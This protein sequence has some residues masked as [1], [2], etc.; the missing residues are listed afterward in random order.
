ME[1]K[2][3]V[4]MEL[5]K[6]LQRRK[7]R[8]ILLGQV[9]KLGLVVVQLYKG[10]H[11]PVHH[12][13]HVVSRQHYSASLPIRRIGS[14]RIRKERERER[15]TLIAIP[16]Q[17][18]TP[19]QQIHPLRR[20]SLLSLPITK[21]QI[22]LPLTPSPGAHDQK[23]AKHIQCLAILLRDTP[24]LLLEALQGDIVVL[25]CI[26]MQLVFAC[27]VEV[28]EVQGGESQDPAEEE[29]VSEGELGDDV[30]VDLCPGGQ[31]GEGVDCGCGVQVEELE[32]LGVEGGV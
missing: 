26:A 16:R 30:L 28:R 20:A 13:C 7:P 18:P 17:R 2:G 15:H 11:G 9:E 31:R 12:P 23:R 21:K 27:G 1:E 6:R 4:V 25:D 5:T 29:G 24:Q 3:Q 14:S 19:P 10:P 22:P 32:V 8:G